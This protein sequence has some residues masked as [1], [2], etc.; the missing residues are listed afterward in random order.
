MLDLENSEIQCND[1]ID[2]PQ[3]IYGATGGLINN[4]TILI[5]GGKLFAN[6]EFIDDCYTLTSNSASF[7]TKMSRKRSS[8]ASLV[9]P[10][11]KSLG[12]VEVTM[13]MK[14]LLILL[15]S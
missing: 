1:W 5:C 11:S 12:F 9:N 2:F 3:G 10:S 4:N 13:K 15:K 14:V 7:V 6:E 8:A